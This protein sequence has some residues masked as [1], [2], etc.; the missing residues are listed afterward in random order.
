MHVA[1]RGQIGRS[2]LGLGSGLP[3]H[4]AEHV[5]N[6]LGFPEFGR[7]STGH[8]GPASPFDES[9]ALTVELQ[10]LCSFVV[11]SHSRHQ[12]LLKDGPSKHGATIQAKG[13]TL[14]DT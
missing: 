6:D 1:M 14:H 4:K 9:P 13:S 12:E 5:G 10:A 2:S 11:S 7:F 8:S 3:C